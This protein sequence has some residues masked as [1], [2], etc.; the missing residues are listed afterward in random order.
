ML[1]AAGLATVTRQRTIAK[2]KELAQKKAYKLAQVARERQRR[3]NLDRIAELRKGGKAQAA[4]MEEARGAFQAGQ[5]DAANV[6]LAAR[7][8][9]QEVE[10]L[11]AAQLAD[12]QDKINAALRKAVA[13]YTRAAKVAAADK[14]DESLLRM[15][16]IYA[17]KLKDPTAAMKTYLEIVRQFSGTAVAED[18]SWRIAQY[19]DRQ[20]KY[21]EAIKAYDAFLRNY[22]RSP[23]AGAAQFAIAENYEQL[24]QWV[25][26]MDAYTNYI[27]NF[28]K[29]PLVR[30]ARE[31]INWIKTYRL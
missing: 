29:G 15:A 22:R 18:A 12:R 10:A 1:E 11:T 24:G 13:A 27:N 20:G 2:V 7:R 26:A 19:Y 9:S 6:L 28:P 21:A 5:Y 8:A 31:Q 14:A 23:R 3:Y 17:E 16:G 25:K 4:E 30:K